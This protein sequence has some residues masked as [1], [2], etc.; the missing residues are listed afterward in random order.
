MEELESLEQRIL[1]VYSVDMLY[2]K[3]QYFQRLVTL[4]AGYKT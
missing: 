3:E 4:V 1:G 2:L